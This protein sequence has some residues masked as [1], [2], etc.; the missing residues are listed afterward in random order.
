MTRDALAKA[1]YCRTVAAILRR[2]NNLCRPTMGGNL[3]G[4]TDS[5]L[6]HGQYVLKYDSYMAFKFITCVTNFFIG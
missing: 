5:N 3:S 1:L 2:A 6:H 4:S